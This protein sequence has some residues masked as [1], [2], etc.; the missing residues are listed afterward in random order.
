M[1]NRY[2]LVVGG[3]PGSESVSELFDLRD[4]PGEKND[5]FGTKPEI[6]ENLEKKLRDWQLVLCKVNFYSLWRHLLSQLFV[7]KPSRS[8]GYACVLRRDL[9]QNLLP[10]IQKNLLYRALGVLKSLTGDDYR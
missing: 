6:E 4:D 8:F 1:D 7:A 9:T 10:I 3:Q 5:L 2:K